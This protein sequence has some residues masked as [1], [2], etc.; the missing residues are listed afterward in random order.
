MTCLIL[1][2]LPFKIFLVLTSWVAHLFWAS[3]SFSVRPID[4]P[5]I[6][7][8]EIQNWLEPEIFIKISDADRETEV[9]NLLS[10]F[11]SDLDVP[12]FI[13]QKT[14]AFLPTS[15]KSR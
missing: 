1:N 6:S 14:I 5:S 7:T 15:F 10:N 12:C 2:K 4:P 8:F 11:F 3:R 9:P 13:N